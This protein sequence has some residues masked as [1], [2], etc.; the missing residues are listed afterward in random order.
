MTSHLLTVDGIGPV[1]VTVTERGQGRPILLLHGGGGPLT[2]TPWAD[3]Q[4]AHVLIPTHPGFNATPRPAALDSIGG[5]AA[6]YVALLDAL[7]LTDVTVVGNSIGGWI[8]A[9]MALLDPAR[10]GRYVLVDAVGIEVPGHPVADFFALSP[11]EL[12]ERSYHDPATFG[13][14]PARLPPPVREMMAGNRVTIEVYAGRAMTDPTLAGRLGGV[15]R[16]TLVVW[17]EA[18]RIGDPDFGRAFAAAIPGAGFTLLPETGH[19]PQIETPDALTAVVREFM[20]DETQAASAT[21]SRPAP[22]AS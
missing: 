15:T 5:L 9:E 6:T 18:D 2:V 22:L 7:D 20:R 11:A 4:A 12:A 3:L 10:V 13:V 14:D 21:R 8:A 17:G 1:E 19:L 16:P